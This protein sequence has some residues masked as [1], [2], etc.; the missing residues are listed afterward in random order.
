MSE[1]V[2]KDHVY[3]YGKWAWAT[4]LTFG[5]ALTWLM[6]YLADGFS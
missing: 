4:G 5:L 3:T 6:F 1:P 2:R